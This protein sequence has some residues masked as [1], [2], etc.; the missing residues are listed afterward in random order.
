MN[1]RP[2]LLKPVGP[3]S[4]AGESEF[5]L[6]DLQI[7]PSLLEIRAGDRREII[8]PRVMQVLVTLA[9]A[10]DAVVSRDELIRQ[11]WGGQIVGDDAINRSV[12]KVRALAGLGRVSAF[13]VETIPRVGYRLKLRGTSIDRVRT[14]FDAP[15]APASSAARTA[16]PDS[17]SRPQQRWL[18]QGFAIALITG[19]VALGAWLFWPNASRQW[20]VVRSEVPV[21]TSL[22]ERHPA[23]S[24]DGT[25][26]AYSAGA[27][28]LSRKIY[29]RRITG[30]EPLRLTDDAYDDASPTWSPDSSQIVYVAHKEGEPC[31]LM[32][33]PVL[34]GSAHE[35]GR[36]QTDDR[37]HVVWSASGRE[38]FFLDRPDTKGVDRIMRFDLASGHRSELTRPP[39]TGNGDDEPAV[40]RD[41]RWVTFVRHK[42]DTDSDAQRIVLNLATGAERVL[43]DLASW[44]GVDWSSDSR[45]I[46]L[47]TVAEGDFALWASPLDGNRP[48]RILSSPVEMGRLSSGPNGL[49]AV[50]IRSIN[51]N[52][53][54]SPT[55]LTGNSEPLSPEKGF[56][57]SPDI[58]PDGSIVFQSERAGNGGIWLLPKGGKTVRELVAFHSEEE[59]FGE[60]RWSRDGSR[61]AF[62]TTVADTNEIKII[63]ADGADVS[64]IPFRGSEINSPAWTADGRAIIFPGRTGTGW[65]LWRAELTRPNKLKMISSAGWRYVRVRDDELYGVRYDA[66]GVWRI[67]G[68]PHRITQLPAPER[69]NEWTIAG[70][71]IAYVDNPFGNRRQILAQ[72]INGGIARVMAQVPHYAAV[73]GFAIEPQTGSIIYGATQS[74]D[75]DIELLHLAQH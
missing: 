6:G 17:G 54:R 46:F 48:Y 12:A 70:D 57:Y 20:V 8:Q 14:P 30:G 45:T 27:D 53:A 3:A 24:P 15:S 16:R 36:C 73:G 31:R 75:S 67:D 34:A 7:S 74:S 5:S 59:K 50:E 62:Q 39:P 23:I 66:P 72:P 69:S 51:V 29:V 64:A 33:T 52:L 71:E 65:H 28:I 2:D 42:D 26:I 58:A 21:S 1:F 22:L 4:L 13:E 38:L 10:K 43:P 61:I 32:V 56:D 40:S 11:C 19:A 68:F 49:L 25:M 41:G 44:S 37:S 55:T 35:L 9:R 60:P 63:T 47:T 18:V